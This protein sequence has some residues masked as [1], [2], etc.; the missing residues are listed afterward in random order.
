MSGE[1][2]LIVIECKQLSNRLSTDE[3]NQL[4]RYFSFVPF[5]GAKIGI[6]TNGVIY[7]F[8]TDE[9]E[10]NKMDEEPFWQVNLESLNDNDLTQFK[11]FTK[12]DFDPLGAVQ[13]ASRFKYISGMKEILNQ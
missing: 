8:F 1:R 11:N 13:T 9:A 12:D 2:P 5:V 3:I 4:G 6:L 7:K 10:P